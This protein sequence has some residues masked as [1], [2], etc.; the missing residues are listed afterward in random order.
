MT[1]AV[2][3][4]TVEGWY[5]LHQ[6][7]SVNWAAVRSGAAPGAAALAELPS[8]LEAEVD[9]EEDGWSRAARG[10]GGGADLMLVH[11]R[12]D[13][14]SLARV[15]AGLNRSAIRGVLNPVYDFLSV[16][17]AG[18]YHATAQV[19]A[20]H[21]PGSP[22]YRDA[23]AARVREEA[24][25]G[26]VQG[27]LYPRVPPG[28]RYMSFY[29]MSKRRAGDDNWYSLPIDVRSRLMRDHGLTG[30]GYA[31]RIFQVISGAVGL[32]EWEWGVTLFAHDPLDFKR[33]VTD[34]RFDEVSARYGEFGRFFTGILMDTDDW[35]DLLGAP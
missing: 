16:T 25:T 34:M 10:V 6:L 28:M 30:R 7:F 12:R 31:G 1:S 32:S 5:A 15:Q 8:L 13:L 24:A 27:R 11:F 14:E 33:I 9:S 3:P 2:S 23:L 29:P 19:A 4:A 17:E 20:E 35:A 18:L 21:E 26:H 22:G